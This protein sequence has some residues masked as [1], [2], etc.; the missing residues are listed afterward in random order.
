MSQKHEAV[1][2]A[3]TEKA[4]AFLVGRTITSVRYMTQGECESQDWRFSALVL[5][6]DNG[7]LILPASD[8]EGNNA[9][10][11][12]GQGADGAELTFPVIRV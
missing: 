11:L 12:F 7:A 4:S 10:A 9:G 5:E 6:L 8:D 2:K 1:M 3:W